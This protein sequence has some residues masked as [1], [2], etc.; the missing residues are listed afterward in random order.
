MQNMDWDTGLILKGYCIAQYCLLTQARVSRYN[1]S[2][3]YFE[4]DIFI[5]EENYKLR[6]RWSISYLQL[7]V[8]A[9]SVIVFTGF[10]THTCSIR[11]ILY[12][13]YNMSD[14]KRFEL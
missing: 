8:T 9:S 6:S 10:M 5:L 2:H 1:K 3:F 7:F 13:S 14:T 4:D 12:D 11:V